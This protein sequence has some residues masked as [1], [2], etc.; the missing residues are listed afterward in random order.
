MREWGSE[1]DTMYKEASKLE[2]RTFNI[3]SHTELAGIREVSE[4]EGVQEDNKI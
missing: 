1:T 4:R 2:H 3:L